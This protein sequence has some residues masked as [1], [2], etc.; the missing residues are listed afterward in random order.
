MLNIEFWL[1]AGKGKGKES[2][3]KGEPERRLSWDQN[4]TRPD[5]TRS[6]PRQ[7]GALRAIAP[8]S[9]FCGSRERE[10]EREEGKVGTSQRWGIGE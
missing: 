1:T 9:Y 4:E 5:Q 3:G 6:D 8:L 2:K 7:P 10:R